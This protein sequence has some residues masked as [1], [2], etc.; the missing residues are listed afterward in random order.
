MSFSISFIMPIYN[1]EKSIKIV[2]KNIIKLI[3]FYKIYDYEIIMVNDS[4]V[5]NSDYEIKKLKRNNK[6]VRYIKHK[7]NYGMGEAFRSGVKLSKK[8][9]I[10]LVPG[11][12]EHTFNGLKPLFRNIKNRNFDII[13][14]YVSNLSSRKAS[15]IIISELYT[16]FLNLLFFKRIPYYNGCCLY[17]SKILKRNIVL[18]K[19]PSMTLLSEL[20]LRSLKITNKYRIVSYKLNVKNKYKKTE[21]FKIK[22]LLIG[23]YYILKYRFNFFNK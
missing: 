22:N 13:I 14:P 17:N 6:R 16:L 23:I 7:K 20:L 4:S 15:R 10:L 1:E 9:F 11:D 21:A 18:T 2:Y 8:K 5:D 12:N 3:N 19:N